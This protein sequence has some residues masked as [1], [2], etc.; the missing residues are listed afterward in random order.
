M[1]KPLYRRAS[2]AG[3]NLTLQNDQIRLEFYK[4]I[5]GW[6][7]AEIWTPDNKMMAVLDHFG[8]L[9]VR[10]QEIPMRI[11]AETY[12][13]T[14]EGDT[15][16]L[17]FPVG[18]TMATQKLKGTSFEKW[19]HFPFVETALSGEV[20]F[21]LKDGEAR[22]GMHTSLISNANLYARYLRGVWLLA[23]EGTYG[24][25]KTDSILPGVDWC[26]DKEWSSGTDFFKDPWANRCIP[27]RN[28]VSAP[29]MALSHEGWG[30]GVSWDMN[31]P[32]TRWFNYGEAYAQ[33]VFA[34]PNFIERMNNSLLGLMIPDVK[35]ESEENKPFADVPLEMHI[36][37]HIEWKAD[38]F[39]TPGNSL[40]VM[41]D[42]LKRTGMPAPQ[43]RWEPADALDR[44]ANAFNTNLWH[45]GEGW[46]ILQD[47]HSKASSA[48]PEFLRRYAAE[49]AQTELG[50]QLAEKI[51]W[52]DEKNGGK[53]L[54]NS[55]LGL[56]YS[57]KD[58]LSPD[59]LK[60]LRQ[61]ADEILT[62]QKEDGSFVFEPD[63]RHYTKDDFRVARGFIEPMGLDGDTA[64]HM[65]TQPAFQLME[66]YKLTGE[67][68]YAEAARR[69][70]DFAL[71]YTRPE[72]GDYW[73]TPLHAPNLL[74]AGL[75][76]NVYYMAYQVFG[77]EAYK[78]KAIYWLR[79]LIPFTNFWEPV[80]LPSLYDTKP[81]LCSSDWYFAN[82]VRD[83]VQ[84]EVQLSFA[85]SA[86]LG[87]DWSE[88]DPELDWHT[89][90]K[91]ITCASF[92]WTLLRETNTWRPH[93]LP[94]SYDQY[95]NGEFDY[96]YSDTHNTMTGNIGGMGITP[97]ETALN[98]YN[99]LDREARR[100]K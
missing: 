9:M 46:G 85:T 91:G 41:V 45:E 89:Y 88:I 15:Q 17:R 16:V 1:E 65:N 23:G 33:P 29:V 14:R 22:V 25:E 34:T 44:F 51:A 31:V 18:T 74:A 7:W 87:Y 43:P 28:K 86:R 39:L 38:L 80:N 81:C 99:I 36:G 53:G 24:T 84:W 3:E 11:E 5:C 95:L 26:L 55:S 70:L 52:C 30:L 40:D 54:T 77:V 61:Q 35:A 71:Q 93:N 50:R 72:A 27:H 47:G 90:Q 2:A 21:T 75:G 8:E 42:W 4:R 49:H 79:A 6:G 19:V 58:E 100:E 73:E 96:C 20:V 97:S 78:E 13:L 62:W 94:A 67:E 56:L 83:H 12:T 66:F 57:D 32:V 63:G 59:T 82:W 64:L 68:K 92:Y 69:A 10:D 48:V 60:K 37:Q 98:L 76:M